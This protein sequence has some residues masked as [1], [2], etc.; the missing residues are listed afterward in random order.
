MTAKTGYVWFLPVYV[1]MKVN[2]TGAQDVNG[3]CSA[4]DIRNALDGHFALSY[5]SFGND[6]DAIG[7]NL[8][9]REWKAE[10]LKRMNK[11]QTHYADYAGYTYDAIWVYVK[12]LQQLI[13]EGKRKINF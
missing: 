9:V 1:S 6:D 11:N 12:A 13:E 8:T 3:L 10:Y 2:A 7:G 4:V 5:S